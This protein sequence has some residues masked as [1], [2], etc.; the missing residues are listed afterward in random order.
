MAHLNVFDKFGTLL[1]S[2][3]ISGSLIS[4][5]E[6]NVPSYRPMACPPYSAKLNGSYWHY[7]DHDLELSESDC[8]ELV[9]EP[10]DPLTI[11]LVVLTVASAAYAYYVASNI[12]TGYEN[13]TESGNSIYNANARGNTPSP[14]GVIRSVAGKVEI[15][16]DLICPVHRKF[17]DHEEWLYL[18]LSVGEGYYF[19]REENIYI[20]ET[21]IRNYIG[22]IT[23]FIFEPGDDISGTDA[24]ENW[25]ESEEVAAL[26]LTTATGTPVGSW[27]LDALGDEFTSYLDGVAEPFPFAVG[28]KFEILTGSNVGVYKVDA[29]SGV[30]DEIATVISQ[31]V[32]FLA[33]VEAVNRRN[34]VNRTAAAQR[35]NTR[36][37]PPPG[38]RIN[39]VTEDAP[40]T[41]LATVTDEAVTWKG[42][43]GG[44]NWEGPFEIIPRNETARY[45]EVDVNFPGGLVELNN[46]GDPINKTVAIEVQYRNVGDDEWQ[47]VPSTSFTDNT[48][49]ERGYTIEID[50]GSAIRP[51]L[52]FRR[53]TLESDSVNVSEDV[54]ILRVKAKLTSPTSYADITTIGLEIRGTNALAGTAENKVNIRGAIRKLPTLEEIED[55]ANGT[56]YDLTSATTLQTGASWNINS[57]TFLESVTFSGAGS[58][59]DF[60][61]SSDGFNLI[62]GMGALIYSYEL[63]V[64]F[65][66]STA[67][68]Q[69]SMNLK[70]TLGSCV[71]RIGDG[72]SKIYFLK[73]TTGVI[74]QYD[75]SSPYDL[76]TAVDSGYSFGT[77]GET[78]SPQSFSIENGAKLFVANS[79]GNAFQYT[80]STPWRVSTATYDSVTEDFGSEL[81]AS[82]LTGLRVSNAGTRAYVLAEDCTVYSYTL[83]TA[84]NISTAVYDGDSSAIA[85][86]AP[87]YGDIFVSSDRL[88]ASETNFNA[89]RSF[90]L[91]SVT[92][93]RA[94]RSV[95][96]FVAT[97]L[98][99]VIGDDV[100]DLVD[101]AELDSLDDLL[102]SRE[103]YLDADFQ[104]ET[105]FWEAVKIMLAPGYAE[106]VLKE[107]QFLPVRSSD[108]YSVSHIYMPSFMIGDGLTREDSHYD[109]QEPDGIDV[110]YLDE[111]SGEMEIVECRLSGDSGIRPKRIQAI[112]ITNREKAW[113]YGMRERRRLRYKPARYTF[114]TEMDA[115][116]SNY[117]DVVALA[118]EIFS[119]QVG[120]VTDESGALLTL[121]FSP[122]LGAGTYYAAFKKPDGRYSG[123]Y[124]IAAT[125]T[126]N[127]IELI[128]PATLDFT[129]VLDSSPDE[130]GENTAI[131]IGADEEWAD[132]AV[133]KNIQKTGDFEVE[134]IAEEFLT[135]I[136]ADDDNSPP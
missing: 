83:G 136:F 130:D 116:N 14:S 110:E 81:G 104:D 66:L 64:P 106:P 132:L 114:R 69:S 28:E 96:R 61:I 21:P 62:I 1:E 50:A 74:Y 44:V 8:I 88:F 46:D 26:E 30:D 47:T 34:Q 42:V 35:A 55:A 86:L 22:D 70:S 89:I 19:L 120:A 33:E 78:T 37:R 73:S 118:S 115:L 99:D 71:V 41:T 11:A 126:P 133:I 49:D 4:W 108:D 27:S 109:G 68:L 51:E 91:I 48:Y 67:T 119:S 128:S 39:Y 97:S 53:V 60:D 93:N 7:P 76:S 122:T 52:R 65:V 124:E 80:L 45:I 13:S 105:T 72:G 57:L 107:G 103:D 121:D 5:L 79:D 92:D 56:P 135:E 54:F 10:K 117:G 17:I 29:I 16:P 2:H 6:E 127:V 43:S 31:D 63:S 111:D 123:L 40:T 90:D 131:T 134:V 75:M 32:E 59:N 100:T 3:I 12:P 125:V 58:L 94:T 18:M 77:G 25:F 95:A 129:P 102:E 82:N 84:Y 24:H 15:F 23:P 36:N 112:G 87:S 9:I 113:R 38:T 20:A 101:W 85:S 98:Y